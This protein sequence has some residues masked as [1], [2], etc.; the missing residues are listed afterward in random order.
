MVPGHVWIVSVRL[1]FVL[2]ARGSRYSSSTPS[3]YGHCS[4]TPSSRPFAKDCRERN[5]PHVVIGEL[6]DGSSVATELHPGIR[7]LEPMCL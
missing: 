4:C 5:V 7:A 6:G 2:A 3:A 1:A